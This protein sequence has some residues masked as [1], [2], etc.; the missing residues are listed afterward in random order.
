M[1]YT[2]NDKDEHGQLTPR[3][4]VWLRG[5]VVFKGYYKMFDVTRETVTPD[6]W[7]RTGDVAEFNPRLMSFKIIDRRKNIFKLQQGEY[8]APDRI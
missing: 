8:L 4:E 3:G 5:P 6:G 2:S 7:L 1:K